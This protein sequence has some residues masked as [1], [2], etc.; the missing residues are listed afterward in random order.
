MPDYELHLGSDKLLDLLGD[1]ESFEFGH[2]FGED[3][4]EIDKIIEEEI[5]SSPRSRK[6]KRKG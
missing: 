6:R 5:G 4:D 3:I 2:G 1:E